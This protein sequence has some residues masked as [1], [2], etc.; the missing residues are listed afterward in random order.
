MRL[1][2]RA[3]H[4]PRGV[5][6][7]KPAPSISTDERQRDKVI[8]LLATGLSEKQVASGLSILESDVSDIL[9]AYREALS[10]SRS[11]RKRVLLDEPEEGEEDE[12]AT[13][14]RKL[15]KVILARPPTLPKIKNEDG[16]PLE[17]SDDELDV[18]VLAKLAA[19]SGDSWTDSELIPV[20]SPFVSKTVSEKVAAGQG[21]RQGAS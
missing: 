11:E 16:S 3:A 8:H 15:Q 13:E 6:R 2:K 5:D 9:R 21:F 7:P 12:E 18:S 10:A 20:S 4:A 1:R 17:E 19:A 14:A